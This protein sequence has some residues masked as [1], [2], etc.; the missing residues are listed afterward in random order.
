MAKAI[1]QQKLSGQRRIGKLPSKTYQSAL[2]EAKTARMVDEVVRIEGRA[3]LE[4]WS[5]WRFEL[6]HKKRNW[7]SQWMR[8]EYRASLISGGPRHATHPVNAILN[9]AYSVAAAQLTRSLIA[10]GFDSTAGFLH[11]DAQ[12]RHSLTYDALELVRA[13][14]DARIL[15]WVAS[16]T[17]KRADFPVTPEG[18]VRLQPTLAAYVAEQA[19][20]A[21]SEICRV[22]EWLKVKLL[23]SPLIISKIQR[24]ESR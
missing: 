9:Y 18:V 11:A 24:L 22:V 17:W 4:Y 2:L 8:F 13:D 15:P 10:F 16:H 6:K 1:L 12:G 5:N 3:A 19:L 23:P 21:Q 14:I 20:L 7:P